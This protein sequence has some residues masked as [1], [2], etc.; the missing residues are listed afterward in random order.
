M[1]ARRDDCPD[2]FGTSTKDIQ[3]CVDSDGDGWSD[4]YGE[5]NAAVSMMGESPASSWLSYL[6]VGLVMLLSSG[7][8][9][10]V[11]SRKSV[12]S[13]EKDLIPIKEGDMDA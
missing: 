13:L 9:L 7:L 12:A 8:A 6:T 11:R 4:E 2:I 10:I 1:G 5:W 3:G